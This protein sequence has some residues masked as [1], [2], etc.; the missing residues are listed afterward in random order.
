M[1]TLLAGIE[2]YELLEA[3]NTRNAREAQGLAKLAIASFTTYVRDPVQFQNIERQLL[4]ATS[5]H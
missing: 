2:D 1:E 3:V 4:R 5:P